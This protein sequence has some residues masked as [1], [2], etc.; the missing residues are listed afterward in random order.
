[1]KNNQKDTFNP[2]PN[3][4]PEQSPNIRMLTPSELEALKND[5]RQSIQKVKGRFKDLA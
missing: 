5:M 3:E 4:K 2:S 1:M